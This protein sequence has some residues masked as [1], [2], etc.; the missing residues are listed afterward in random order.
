MRVASGENWANLTGFAR[1]LVQICSGVERVE[2]R[3]SEEEPTRTSESRPQERVV[4]E[5]V[6]SVTG[7]VPWRDHYVLVSLEIGIMGIYPCSNL[8]HSLILPIRFVDIDMCMRARRYLPRLL[9]EPDRFQLVL[10]LDIDS[11]QDLVWLV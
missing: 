5:S 3:V 6:R 8:Q 10:L 1:R 7:R 4:I 9:I 11:L 2:K